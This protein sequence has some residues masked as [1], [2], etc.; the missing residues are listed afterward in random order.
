MPSVLFVCTANRFRSPIASAW[1]SKRLQGEADVQDWRVGSAG[2][3]AEPGLAFFPSADWANDHFGVNL[4]THRATRIDHKILTQYD[5]FLVMEKSHQE[6]L[7]IEFPEL[8]DR[9]FLLTKVATG[10]AYDVPDPGVIQDDSF[11]DIA[12]ELT[13]LIDMGFMEICLLARK[14]R[15]LNFGT[16]FML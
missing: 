8:K 11:L 6:A 15:R 14:M 1:F 12:R 10:K 2:T 4:E 16:H 5:L 13:N 7:R 3:W 9:I